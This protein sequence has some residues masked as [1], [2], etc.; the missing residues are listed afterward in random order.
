MNITKTGN[1]FLFKL[2]MEENNYGDGYEDL[3]VI[4]ENFSS[5][6]YNSNG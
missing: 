6:K 5:I 4:K 1:S 2:I 3:I